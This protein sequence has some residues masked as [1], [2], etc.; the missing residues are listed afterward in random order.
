MNLIV[1]LTPYADESLTG[2]LC[3][4]SER[5]LAPDVKS[6]LRSFGMKPRLSY[7]EPELTL[8]AA[9]L[10]VDVADLAVRQ[11]SPDSPHPMLRPKYHSLVGHKV[12]PACIA[13]ASYKRLGWSH[14]LVTA[15]P[16]HDIQL[17]STCGSCGD[18]IS[19]AGHLGRCACGQPYALAPKV[20]ASRRDLALSA[21]LLGYEH[22]A[23]QTLP[24]AWRTGTPP[25]D[26][27]DLLRLLGRSLT[28]PASLVIRPPSPRGRASSDQ[29]VAAAG[30]GLNLLLNWPTHFDE[31]LS[32]RL[33]STEGP[34]LA[35]RLG[36][37]YRQLHQ[38]HTD[39]VYD[40][41]RQAL[42]Q[43]LSAN[44][45]GHLNLRI[46]TID[47]QHLT[48]KCWLT[49]Q[50]AGRLM[51]IGS[52]LVRSAVITSEIV[53]KVSIKGQNRFVS[54]HRDVV[55]TVRQNRLLYVTTTEARRRLGV[56]K[57]VFERLIQSGALEKKT[58]AQRPALVSAEFLAK[59][60]D[61]LV[62]RLL[63]GVLPRQIEKSLWA[64]FQDIS[65]KRGIP[66]ASICVIMQKILHQEIRPIALLPGASGVSGLRFDFSEIKA[67]IAEDEP[68]YVL[69]I[70]EL[71]H[72]RGWKHESIKS[73][74]DAGFLQARTEQVQG[75]SRTVIPL[76]AL[77]DFVSEFAV[78]ADLARRTE[79]KSVWLLRGLMPAGVSPVLAPVTSQG[80][81][82]GLLL[83]ID[84]LLAASQLN[85]RGQ[86]QRQQTSV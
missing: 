34:G 12:C 41:L 72:M 71:S 79:T 29:V 62:S 67:C 26:I 81:K 51:G 76:T 27:A 61:A 13:D 21:L 65:I 48:D 86:P 63:E 23:R 84:D 9:T 19:D 35:K 69:S 7:A 45:D 73:W 58:K 75:Q 15:C 38:S 77:L 68:E 82:R 11:M 39:S 74:I 33:S 53:G 31:A 5:N 42:V 3:R 32:T 2:F 70:S 1:R 57:L 83:R 66:D 8:L 60:V 36:G 47:P 52:E 18:G 37:W 14:I 54:V 25:G 56:S 6:F 16:V 10:H 22:T 17:I 80:A 28:N 50:E 24:P 30:A 64:G 20:S 4:V 85:K 55:E 49:S 44:F 59:D 43:H 78:L 46:S 40:C